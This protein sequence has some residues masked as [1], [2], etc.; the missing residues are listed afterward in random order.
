MH[1]QP[2]GPRPARPRPTLEC[3]QC[4]NALFLPEWSELLDERHVRHLWTCDTCDYRFE[5]TVRFAEAA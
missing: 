5:T 3:A 4:G 1:L 2:H